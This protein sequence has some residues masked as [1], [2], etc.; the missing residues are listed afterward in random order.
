MN[1]KFSKN[2]YKGAIKS[3]VLKFL[4]TLVLR[5]QDVKVSRNQSFK[6]WGFQDIKVFKVSIS[7]GF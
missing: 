2:F 1:N 3:Q 6:V 4:G 5:F 7:Q